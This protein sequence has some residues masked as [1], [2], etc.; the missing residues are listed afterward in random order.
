MA[1]PST[2]KDAECL[3]LLQFWYNRQLSE[4]SPT[5]R[6][7]YYLVNEV[8][9]SAAERELVGPEPEID[10]DT[11]APMVKCGKEKKSKKGKGKEV[12]KGKKGGKGKKK[13]SRVSSDE[14]EDSAVTEAESELEFPDTPSASDTSDSDVETP[15]SPGPSISES[16]LTALIFEIDCTPQTLPLP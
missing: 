4:L 1:E 2:I 12:E 10:E 11:V 15:G 16:N 14:D 8:L 13:A 7:A 5:F 6:F 9:E 3:K